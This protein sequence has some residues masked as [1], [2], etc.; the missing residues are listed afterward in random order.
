MT[1]EQALRSYTVEGAYASYEENQ[2]GQICPGM[3]ADFV[4]LSKDPFSVSPA[5]LS[6][7]ETVATYL[8]GECVFTK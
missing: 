3:T 4:I 2:K 7:I 5:K 6:Q 8:G 1:V